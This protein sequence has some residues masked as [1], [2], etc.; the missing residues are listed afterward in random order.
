VTPARFAVVWLIV[1]TF[2]AIDTL[3][4]LSLLA[5]GVAWWPVPVALAVAF[6]VAWGAMAWRKFAR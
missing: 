2:A 6:H 1:G 3:L 5:L 4:A